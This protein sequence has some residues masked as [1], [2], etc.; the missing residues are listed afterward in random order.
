MQK[1]NSKTRILFLALK[2][3][4]SAN[5][6]QK[7]SSKIPYEYDRTKNPLALSDPLHGKRQKS[8]T[9]KCIGQKLFQSV[10]KSKLN[11]SV[12]FLIITFCMSSCA[13]FTTDSKSAS[14]SVFFLHRYC[15]LPIQIGVIRAD[16]KTLKTFL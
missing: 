9:H 6:G 1:W 14:N 16:E 4:K 3:V 12:T 5:V 15:F 8:H 7:M 11:C 10:K 2:L 13:N